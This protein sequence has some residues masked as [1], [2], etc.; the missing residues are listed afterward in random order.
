MAN[1]FRVGVAAALLILASAVCRAQELKVG[2]DYRGHV[3]LSKGL[4]GIVL[5]LPDGAWRLVDLKD[6]RVTDVDYNLPVTSGAFV[7]L[8]LDRARQQVKSFIRY[9]IASTDPLYGGW[10]DSP[11]CSGAEHYYT[12]RSDQNRRRTRLQCWSIK[13]ETVK[14]SLQVPALLVGVS[15]FWSAGAKALQ[16][17]YYFNPETAGF[18]PLNAQDWSKDGIAAEPKRARYIEDLKTWGMNWQPR[19]EQG[20]SGKAPQ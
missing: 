6:S 15:Y 20:F 3:E 1:A 10:T 13:L 17:T 12:H 8:D 5:P 11:V 14:P 18:P 4:G 7:S 19:I 16:A 2:S 9:S